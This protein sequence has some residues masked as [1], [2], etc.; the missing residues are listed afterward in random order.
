MRLKKILN[1]FGKP[2]LTA[3]VPTIRG[4]H[5]TVLSIPQTHT[6]AALPTHTPSIG[7]RMKID[8]ISLSLA[9]SAFFLRTFSR[10][11]TR[12][13]IARSRHL[14]ERKMRETAALGC[15]NIQTNRQR[16][17]SKQHHTSYNIC[18]CSEATMIYST[19]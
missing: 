7:R 9:A 2:R 14:R 15:T 4:T 13:T 1:H 5:S 6:H 8:H 17:T 10:R 3:H 11:K 19:R 12:T 16:T 18:V